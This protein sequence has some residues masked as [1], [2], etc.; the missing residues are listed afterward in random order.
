[1]RYKP[2]LGPTVF[3]AGEGERSGLSFDLLDPGCYVVAYQC[4]RRYLDSI[5]FQQRFNF[6]A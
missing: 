2:S 1:M 6:A 4:S 5:L 3:V